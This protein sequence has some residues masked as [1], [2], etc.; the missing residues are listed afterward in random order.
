MR[1]KG[2]VTQVEI[3]GRG[4]AGKGLVSK[5][6]REHHSSFKCIEHIIANW[7]A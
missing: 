6:A 5:T 2:E 4:E 7:E 3:G 1:L